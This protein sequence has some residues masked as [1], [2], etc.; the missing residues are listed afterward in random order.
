MADLPIAYQWLESLAEP[1]PKIIL[2]ALALFG[3][4]EI[5][6]PKNDPRIMAWAKELGIENEYVADAVPWCGLFA[7]VVVFRAG[8]S[9]V[10]GPLWARNWAAFGD[11]S[12]EPGLGDILVFQRE[13]GA[14]VG[15]YVGEDD[16]AFHVLG[17]NEGDAVSIIRIA[18]DRLI[19]CRRPHWKIAKPASVKPYRLAATGG[20]SSN[21]A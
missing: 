5:P 21:E 2:K 6:G 11:P 12:P 20:L 3:I 15:F 13:G 18:K 1:A 19:A 14:H 10:H 17:G 7:A 8:G 9:P 16:H 4:R